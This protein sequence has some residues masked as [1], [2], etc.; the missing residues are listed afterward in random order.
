[1]TGRMA[2]AKDFTSLIA[3]ARLLVAEGDDGWR[4]LFVGGG[5]TAQISSVRLPGSWRR[6]A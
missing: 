6:G 2:P 3:A 5:A 4:F 1:M